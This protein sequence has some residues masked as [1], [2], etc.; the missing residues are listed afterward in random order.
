M[1]LLPL[2]VFQFHHAL[3]LADYMGKRN[4]RWILC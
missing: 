4:S 2:R 3:A 1:I